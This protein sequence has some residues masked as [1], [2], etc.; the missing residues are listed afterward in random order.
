MD[1]FLEIEWS[2][3][4]YVQINFSRWLELLGTSRNALSSKGGWEFELPLEIGRQFGLS[5]KYV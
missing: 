1:A 3:K 2:C 5:L 4:I